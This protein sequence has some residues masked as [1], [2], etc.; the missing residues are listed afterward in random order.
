MKTITLKKI[1]RKLSFARIA[2]A[3]VAMARTNRVLVRFEM[4]PAE[5][6]QTFV[7]S[8]RKPLATL[9][10]EW[11]RSTPGMMVAA[12]PKAPRK[13]RMVSKVGGSITGTQVN[14][15]LVVSEQ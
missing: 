8:P 3:A 1:N 6:R 12:A 15:K 14:G 9:C 11:A 5:H 10:W 4:G 2:S 7:A 13:M